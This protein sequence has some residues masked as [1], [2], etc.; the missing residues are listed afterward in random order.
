MRIDARTIASALLR[1]AC[2]EHCA[3]PTYAHQTRARTRLR[4]TAMTLR[5]TLSLAFVCLLVHACFAHDSSMAAANETLA[6]ARTV[7]PGAKPASRDAA[8]VN[9]E[10]L[11]TVD[12]FTPCKSGAS[13]NQVATILGVQASPAVAKQGDR[14]TVSISFSTPQRILNGKIETSFL[15]GSIELGTDVADL[16]SM[17]ASSKPVSH[18]PLATGSYTLSHGFLVPADVP[19]NKYS[20]RVAITSFSGETLACFVTWIRVG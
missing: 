14:V 4:K 5:A 18:C 11:Q 20:I 17:L 13:R 12:G 19:S 8:F 2:H 10:A 15:F 3:C 16:C 6:L 9:K 7:E 1:D